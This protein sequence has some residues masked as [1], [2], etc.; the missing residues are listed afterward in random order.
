VILG[1]DRVD[2][3]QRDVAPLF[4][5]FAERCRTCCLCF[6]E[7]VAAEDGGNFV[8]LDRNQA[9]GL[10]A[11]QRTEALLHARDRKS[12]P[13]AAAHFNRNQIAVLGVGGGTGGNCDFAQVLFVDRNQAA[14]AVG[15]RPEHPEHAMLGVT[16]DLDDATTVADR[17]AFFTALLGAQQNLIA[18]PGD[19]A[20]ARTTRRLDA[21]LRCRPV[22]FLVPFLRGCDQVSVLIAACDIR[23]H[24]RRKHARMVQ[25]LAPALDLALIGKPAEHALERGAIIVFQ[26][27]GARDLARADLPGLAADEGE[28]VLSGWERWLLAGSWGQ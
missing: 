24:H 12:K 11:R 22:R 23:H 25:L 2:G 9:H 8:R 4:A 1:I 6:G 7:R 16:D 17:V 5:A 20:R 19:F 28:D 18:Y 15:Q 26:A 10:F 27:E 21:D 13:A 3:D 14:A